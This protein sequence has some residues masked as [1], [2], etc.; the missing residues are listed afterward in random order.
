MRCSVV[1]CTRNRAASLEQ[2][3][4]SLQCVSI[5]A[6]L[7]CEILV[8]DNGSSDGTRELVQKSKASNA[9]LRYMFEPSPGLSKARN[10]ALTQTNAEIIIFTDDDLR[11]PQDWLR[12]MCEPIIEGKGQAVA[13]QVRIA[14]HLERN[15]MTVRHRSW[16]ASTER[17]DPKSPSDIVGASMAFHSSVLERV[18]RFDNE[19]G[20]GALGFA[21]DTLFSEQLLQCGFRICVSDGKPAIHHFQED[22]LLRKNWLAAAEKMGRSVAYLCHHW[23]HQT[24]TRA[25]FRYCRAF[26]RYYF[27]RTLRSR[28]CSTAEGIP[29]WELDSPGSAASLAQ[30]YRTAQMPAQLRQ[31]RPD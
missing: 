8:V 13:G 18:P 7:D 22:R 15:W 25:H 4:L 17:L 2:T 30:I 28:E 20:S 19:L 31:A 12:G 24:V 5:P 14:P 27:W 6:G 21:E 29:L 26:A 9:S 10:T 11:F 1:I 3:L 16:Y 23:R